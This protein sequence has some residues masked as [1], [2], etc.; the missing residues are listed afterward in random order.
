M[1]IIRVRCHD[2]E[3]FRKLYDTERP[4]GAMFCPTTQELAPNTPVVIELVCKVLPNRV[5]IKGA[6]LS[7]RPALPRLR[8]RAGAMVLFAPEEAPKRDFVLE[9]LGG[10]LKPA[11][12]R[13]ARL[14][15]GMPVKVQIGT[16]SAVPA[17]LREISVT[18]AL[19]SCSICP[20]IGAAVVIEVVPPGALAPMA[21]SGRVMYHAGPLQMGVKFL[22]RDGGGSRR[23]RELVRRFKSA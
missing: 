9:C 12:R 11:R 8:V 13:H 17:D 19:L 4:E 20:P 23:L 5:L 22:Y 2:A 10:T 18:G 16:K 15:V 3:E 1:N 7:W 14:P 21:I 6:V